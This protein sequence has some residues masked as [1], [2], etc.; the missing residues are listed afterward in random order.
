MNKFSLHK[1]RETVK[2]ET[3]FDYVESSISTSSTTLGFLSL[4]SLRPLEGSKDPGPEVPRPM[5]K[6]YAV[7]F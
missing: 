5:S 4:R 3:A 2:H 7:S 6:H 1:R